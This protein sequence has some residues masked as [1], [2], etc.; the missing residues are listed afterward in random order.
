MCLLFNHAKIDHVVSV[1]FYRVFVQHILVLNV[2]WDIFMH[3]V[4]IR[5]QGQNQTASM[6]GP[7]PGHFEAK[8]KVRALCGQGQVTRYPRNQDEAS[9]PIERKLEVDQEV[10]NEVRSVLQ[11]SLKMRTVLRTACYVC[12]NA[13]YLPLNRTP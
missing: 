5:G 1:G 12:V 2:C 4:S 11:L 3:S 8:R 13:I 6:P 9:T 10:S 7:L